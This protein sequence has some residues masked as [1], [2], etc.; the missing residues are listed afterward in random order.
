MHEEWRRFLEILDE[1]MEQP[2]P[3][4]FQEW[5]KVRLLVDVS[6]APAGA[7]GFVIKVVQPSKARYDQDGRLV[8]EYEVV[9]DLFDPET[10]RT[11]GRSIIYVE[12]KQLGS[13]QPYTVDK[14]WEERQAS[15]SDT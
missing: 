10:L 13:I 4:R 9:V 14:A 1:F 12:E 8:F 6:E 2:Q 15:D 11:Y 5:D 3:N 7:E